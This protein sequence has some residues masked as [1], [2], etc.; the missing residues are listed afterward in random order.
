MI[1]P[2]FWAEARV[3]KHL[4]ER[5]ITVRRFGW[6]DVSEAEAQ[7]NAEARAQEAMER[8]LRGETLRRREPRVPYNGADG[9]PIR[10]E[11]VSRHGDTVLTRNCYGALCL[12]T[13]EVAFADVDEAIEWRAKGCLTLFTVLAAVSVWTGWKYGTWQMAAGMLIAALFLSFVLS[14]AAHRFAIRLRGGAASIARRGIE[15]FMNLHPDW[16]VR[17]YRTPAGYRVLVLH[18]VMDP[19]SDAVAEFFSATGTDPQYAAMCRAQNCFRARVS[20]KPWRIG[21][22]RVLRPRRAAWPVPPELLPERRE[23]V[24]DYEARAEGYASCH[25]LGEFGNGPVHSSARAVQQLHDDLCRAE[26]SLPLA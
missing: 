16:L 24:R 15:R 10:E 2:Q 13:P 26:S 3:V 17:L 7:E 8:I 12:N 6:S 4:P 25:F 23:W 19:R 9:V 18:S 5:Q 1:V 22:D 20:P 11:I 14:W 21:M